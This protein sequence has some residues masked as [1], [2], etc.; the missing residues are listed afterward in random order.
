MPRI[1]GKKVAILVH[2]YF[3]QAEL[4]EP[5]KMLEQAGVV[6]EI[7]APGGGMVQGMDH[8]D[9]ADGFH[10]DTKL[11]NA[12]FDNYDALLLPGGG[13][14]ADMLRMEEKARQWVRAYMSEKKPLAVICHAPWLLVS[15]GV[16]RGRT[17]TSFF[18][19]Q[20]DIRNAGGTW[21]DKDVVIDGNLITSR[22]PGDIPIFTETFMNMLEQ[23]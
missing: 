19:I 18:T 11:S 6:T 23:Q 17:L 5:K 9:L 20:D 1:E 7:I 4:V 22:N 16:A 10:V 3:E 8:T 13:I 14:N 21:V 12:K 15:A 2:N